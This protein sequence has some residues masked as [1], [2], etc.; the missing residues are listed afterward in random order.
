MIVAPDGHHL[1]TFAVPDNVI[2]S[3]QQVAQRQGDTPDGVRA[4]VA[5]QTAD[6]LTRTPHRA[7]EALAF[8]AALEVELPPE[9]LTPKNAYRDQVIRCGDVVARWLTDLDDDRFVYV[10]PHDIVDTG[11]YADSWVIV[12]DA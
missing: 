2:R 5:E 4:E 8:A 3:A 11:R 1:I 10:M 6:S 9:L 7:L 12:E